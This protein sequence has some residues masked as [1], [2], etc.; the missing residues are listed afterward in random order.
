MVNKL[1]SGG[2]CLINNT[3]DTIV[4]RISWRTKSNS[5]LDID[6]S[7]FLLNKKGQVR[8]DKDFIF[9]NQPIA[10]DNSITLDCSPNKS[11][12][13]S[14]FHIL[15]EK[16]PE[17]VSKIAFVINMYQ[18]VERQQNFSMVD[19]ISFKIFEK[20]FKGKELVRY[21]VKEIKQD[22][23]LILGG[24]YRNKGAWSFGAIGQGFNGGLDL[25]A[26][27]FGVS[28]EGTSEEDSQISDEK[29]TQQGKRSI[30]QILSQQAHSLQKSIDAFLPQI[31]SAV[32]QKINESNTR[33]ILDKM[34][35]DAFG[36]ELDEIK[37]EQ[38][39]Q[40]RRADYI[41]SVDNEDMLVVEAKKAGMRLQ[42]KQIF[43]A[44]S[45]GAY[46]GIKWALLTNLKTW[47]LYYISTQEKVEAN[48]VFSIDLTRNSG[49]EDF[50]KLILISRY[51]ISKK[52]ML[53]KLRD[54]INALRPE[55]IINAIISEEV[56]NKV[57]LIVRRD[58]G[59]NV[60]NEKIQK[61]IK[62]ILRI[63]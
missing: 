34:F 3:T 43:Q 8:S 63:N 9:Y 38:K 32:E 14:E 44:T 17:E 24:I 47:Q 58:T 53:A 20:D 57:R 35:M 16:I 54:E 42:D 62:E 18:A 19:Q 39:I 12:K 61:T 23:T 27:R 22:I 10:C 15:L 49:Q 26:S 5:D 55:N 2:N 6:T 50:E 31:N 29:K 41:L 56:I 46:S 45:Y 30:Q 7:S 60:A 1:E 48:L 11:N 28:I 40:G 21:D 36:Y 52:R 25:L 13:D 33:M 4:I 37:A 51:G 59:C